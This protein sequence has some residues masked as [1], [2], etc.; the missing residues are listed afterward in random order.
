MDKV[1]EII[2]W[3]LESGPNLLSAVVG[4]LTALIALCLLI[5]GDSPEKQ[6]QG[7]VNFLS[8]FSKK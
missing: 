1:L 6:L 4:L 2:K 5:P 8:K 3:C 7:V